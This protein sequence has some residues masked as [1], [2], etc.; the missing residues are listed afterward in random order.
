MSTGRWLKEI[1]HRDGQYWVATA[2]GHSAGMATVVRTPDGKIVMAGKMLNRQWK[3]WWW[4]VPV[5]EPLPPPPAEWGAEEEC[6]GCRCGW[7]IKNVIHL[8][9]GGGEMQIMRCWHFPEF[10]C[11]CACRGKNHGAGHEVHANG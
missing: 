8:A 4:S 11:E 5:T 7:P 3:G 1:P 2:Q 6:D 10:S 9:E